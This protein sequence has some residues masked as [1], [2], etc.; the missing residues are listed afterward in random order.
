MTDAP[1]TPRRPPGKR[2]SFALAV[3]MHVLLAVLI[4]YGI[5]W[6]TQQ[7]ETVEVELV[8]AAPPA[9]S[10]APAPEPKPEPK[11][12]P[13]PPLKPEPKP[14]PVKPPPKPEIA[15][16]EKPK[17]KPEPRPV[18]KPEPEPKPAPDPFKEQLE[19][20]LKD[21]EKRK[22]ADAAA[23]EL[24]NLK[25]QQAK[26]AQANEMGKYI[27]AIRGKVR[28]N[29]VLPPDVRGNPEAVFEVTQL[30]SGEV[31]SVKLKKSSGN[32]AWDGATERAILKSSPL[33][34]PAQSELFSRTLELTFRPR[35][36]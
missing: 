8:R 24:A 2:I 36:E 13:P 25:A 28:G 31:L 10:P 27:A 32:P 11:P 33:P 1:A 4:I 3:L 16:K 14:E 22:A 23:Q 5:R 7:P 35:E 17:P 18:S 15:Q 34:K 19:R 21:A 12:E 6:Q 9:P 30:P 20:E 29:I 26:S